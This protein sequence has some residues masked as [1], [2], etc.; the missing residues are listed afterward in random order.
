MTRTRTKM[1][2]TATRIAT[3]VAVE[4]FMP[5]AGPGR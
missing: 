5:V 3:G 4:R 1:A 2:S